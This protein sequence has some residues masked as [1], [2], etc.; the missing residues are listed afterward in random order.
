MKESDLTYCLNCILS[1]EAG[2][3]VFLGTGNLYLAL[4]TFVALIAL[5]K[6]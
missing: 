5:I 2:V 3:F 4:A 1:I 6:K